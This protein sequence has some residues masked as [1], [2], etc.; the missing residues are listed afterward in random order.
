MIDLKAMKELGI[1]GF[2]NQAKAW[3][4]NLKDSGWKVKIYLRKG[5]KSRD[6]ATQMGL[7]VFKLGDTL[8]SHVA[9]LTPDESHVEI[10]E[11][12]KEQSNTN[13]IY[14]HGYSLHYDQLADKYPQFNHLLCA[15]K[16]IASELRFQ[17]ESKGK[18]GGVYS[19]EKVEDTIAHE[20]WLKELAQALGLTSF[21]PA[22]IEDETKADLFSEQSLLCSVLPY[23][24]LFSFNKL[25]EKGI[26]AEV[27]FFETW[28]E[29]KLIAD[30]LI[31]VGPEKFFQLISPNALLGSEIGKEMLFNEHYQKALEDLYNKI[32]DESFIQTVNSTEMNSLR[33]KILSFWKKQELTTTF[34]KMK[35]EL[36]E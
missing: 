25:R 18:L 35:P 36:F 29:V 8:P 34:D 22:T 14:A 12:L 21:H 3:A 26:S 32:E 19:L 28:Y 23:A 31:Q 27:A 33:E 13:F 16:A 30:T 7:D 2:G 20:K 4:M 11:A 24:S 10:L 9:M 15:P 6:I 1:I 5:S 17:F